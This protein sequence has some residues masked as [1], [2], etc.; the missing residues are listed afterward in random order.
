[1]VRFYSEKERTMPKRLF[2]LLLIVLG[3]LPLWAEP[4]DKHS[5]VLE[6]TSYEVGGLRI[7]FDYGFGKVLPAFDKEPDFGGMRLPEA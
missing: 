2:Y 3:S 1:M 7:N 6:P 5:F 4:G